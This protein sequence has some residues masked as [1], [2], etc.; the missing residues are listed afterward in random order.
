MPVNPKAKAKV[1]KAKKA[2]VEEHTVEDDLHEFAAAC[3]RMYHGKEVEVNTGEQVTTL[4]MSDFE[5]FQKNLIRGILVDAVGDAIIVEF[6]TGDGKKEILINCWSIISISERG[7][8]KYAY[9][10]KDFRVNRRAS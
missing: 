8:M 10:D 1:A 5:C 6:D 7:S 2:S 3:L 9:I 4:I